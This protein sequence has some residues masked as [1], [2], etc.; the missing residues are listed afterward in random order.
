MVLARELSGNS[1]YA[2]PVC[3][4][5]LS[6][7]LV[8]LSANAPFNVYDVFAALIT[9][10]AILTEWAA[11]EQLHRFRKTDNRN[12][13]IRSGLWRYSRHP[14]YLGEISFWGGMFLFV[15]S[16]SGFRKFC[17]VLDHCRTD[18]HDFAFY[19]DQYSADGKEK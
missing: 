11:D 5:G 4:P 3:F 18:I 16:A 6:S 19:L 9:L 8:C 7:A 17:R 10:S 13:F 15:L 12:A 2:H 1:F 14:N